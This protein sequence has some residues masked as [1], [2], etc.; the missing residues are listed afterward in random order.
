MSELGTN[1]VVG[2][3]GTVWHRIAIREPGGVLQYFLVT[4]VG[5]RIDQL[6]QNEFESIAEMDAYLDRVA[7]T[8]AG[9]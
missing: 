2:D 3:D 8:G 6:D 7:K 5:S 9:G 4:K 1:K